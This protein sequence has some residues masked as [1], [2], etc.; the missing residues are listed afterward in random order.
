MGMVFHERLSTVRSWLSVWGKFMLIR[1]DSTTSAMEIGGGLGPGGKD[2]AGVIEE[3]TSTTEKAPD[4]PQ[5]PGDALLG[6]QRTVEIAELF[7]QIR[8][9]P[10]CWI[11]CLN[12]LLHNHLHIFRILVVYSEALQ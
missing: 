11:V 4:V 7:R 9:I 3:V 1:K 2:R 10:E 6:L 5:R 12:D 8:G